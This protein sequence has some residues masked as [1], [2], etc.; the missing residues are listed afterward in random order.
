MPYATPPRPRSLLREASLRKLDLHR[1]DSDGEDVQAA[2]PHLLSEMPDN[3]YRQEL[4][5]LALP[6]RPSRYFLRQ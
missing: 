6:S 1:P 2:R 4:A 3:G 5:G